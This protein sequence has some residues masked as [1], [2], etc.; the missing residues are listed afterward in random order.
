MNYDYST[1]GGPLNS[2][3]T[4]GNAPGFSPLAGE[5]ASAFAAFRA[6]QSALDAAERHLERMDEEDLDPLSVADDCQA[7]AFVTRFGQ[8]AHERMPPRITA[9]AIRS[10]VKIW[11]KNTLN[12]QPTRLDQPVKAFN[13][14]EYTEH[15]RL[16]MIPFVKIWPFQN[17]VSKRH[18]KSQMVTKSPIH[19]FHR[20]GSGSFVASFLS[21]PDT[22]HVAVMTGS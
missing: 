7:F 19:P 1:E 21:G 9:G 13:P 5:S 18:K 12:S 14:Q 6:C 15:Q 3:E 8:C 4:V 22:G 16:A 17:G 11:P 10:A 2:S 20:P